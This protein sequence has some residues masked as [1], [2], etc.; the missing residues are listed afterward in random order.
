METPPRFPHLRTP[1]RSRSI[2]PQVLPQAAAT[3]EPSPRISRR[4]VGPLEQVHTP[5]EKNA[6]V[7]ASARG[8][9]RPA[10]QVLARLVGRKKKKRTPVRLPGFPG[11]EIPPAAQPGN[12]AGDA[13]TDPK[14]CCAGRLG[15]AMVHVRWTP[16]PMQWPQ[17]TKVNRP[18]ATTSFA[19]PSPPAANRG[20]P[21]RATSDCPFAAPPRPC[22]LPRLTTPTGR[23]GTIL[24]HWTRFCVKCGCVNSVF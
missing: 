2:L 24:M 11:S 12:A 21:S 20:H 9:E 22:A 1:I 8:R 7:S 14:S 17:K 16:C 5:I 10:A 4:L 6:P 23:T 18:S 15:S 13:R 19:R 3:P